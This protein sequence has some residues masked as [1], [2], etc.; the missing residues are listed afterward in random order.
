MNVPDTHQDS[1]SKTVFGFWLYLLTDFV[2]FATVL[3]SY[4][5][6]R[7]STFGGP[8]ARDLLPLSLTL[9]Q[10]VLLLLASLTAGIGNAYAHRKQ[11][12]PTLFW[13][14]LTFAIGLL[15]TLLEYDG[16]AH[17]I[18]Q[19]Y[20]WQKSAFLSAYFTLIGTH[21]AHMIFALLWTIVLLP[22]VLFSPIHTTCL[23][24]L[25]C[26]RLFWQFVNLIWIGIFTL[27]YLM[28]V[29]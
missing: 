17:L 19:G 26:L 20:G 4:F 18:E 14:S 28:G 16:M 12:K 29:S 13:F 1:Y 9:A 22:A 5:V 7:N 2:L 27:V 8:T 25:T 23:Q 15:F 3:A 10:S 6:L 24:R 11:R 21:F